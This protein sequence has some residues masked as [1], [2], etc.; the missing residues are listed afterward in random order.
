MRKK[1]IFMNSF[2]ANLQQVKR[3]FD[4]ALLCSDLQKTIFL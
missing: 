2:Q 3:A 4:K 1:S